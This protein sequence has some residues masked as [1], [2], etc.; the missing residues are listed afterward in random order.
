MD[1]CVLECGATAP[2]FDKRKVRQAFSTVLQRLVLL[3]QR[4][5]RIASAISKSGAAA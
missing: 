1:A 2:L 5:A 4:V 3:A